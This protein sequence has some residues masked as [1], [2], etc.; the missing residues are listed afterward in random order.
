MFN[1][2]HGP[3]EMYCNITAVAFCDEFNDGK[4]EGLANKALI[5][6]WPV[7]LVKSDLLKTFDAHQNS[8]CDS[9]IPASSLIHQEEE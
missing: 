2:T 4:G 1:I 9:F 7:E 6:S 3:L 5:L 8:G